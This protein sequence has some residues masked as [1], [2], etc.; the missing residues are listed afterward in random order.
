MLLVRGFDA[1]FEDDNHE[2]EFTWALAIS[3]SSESICSKEGIDGPDEASLEHMAHNIMV[4]GHMWRFRRW[5]FKRRFRIEDDI[6]HQTT[7]IM[8]ELTGSSL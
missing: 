1:V 5:F 7:L 2:G 8:R 6:S 3:L 4:L